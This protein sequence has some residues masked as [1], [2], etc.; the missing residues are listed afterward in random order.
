MWNFCYYVGVNPFPAKQ[1]IR[2][3]DGG[4]DLPET[5]R[6][7]LRAFLTGRSAPRAVGVLPVFDLNE[8]APVAQRRTAEGEELLAL[9]SKDEGLAWMNVKQ[10]KSIC[11]LIGAKSLKKLTKPGLV[12]ALGPLM[13]APL[14]HRRVAFE[15]FQVCSQSYA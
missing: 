14:E 13:F 12:S 9:L 4:V 15:K 1:L 8:I 5:R 10:L 6:A 7:H 3:A 11:D 2:K